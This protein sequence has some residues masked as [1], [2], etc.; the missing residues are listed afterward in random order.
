MICDSMETQ[1]L[2]KWIADRVNPTPWKPSHA[3]ACWVDNVLVT[4]QVEKAITESEGHRFMRDFLH[5]RNYLSKSKFYMINWD[6]V[7]LALTPN[8]V[9]FS[10]WS[11]RFV[12]SFCATS[13]VLH[14]C[15]LKEDP[16]CPC[17]KQEGLIKDTYHVLRCPAPQ[18]RK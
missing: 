12:S 10:L 15:K 16:T 11:A 1:E 8:P 14:Q 2:H 3:W 17:C 4:G 9:L 13:K 7:E 18:T 6:A 5:K